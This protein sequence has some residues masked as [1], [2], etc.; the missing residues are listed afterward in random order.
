MRLFQDSRPYL[1]VGDDESLSYE[2]RLRRYRA[3]AD[4]YFS[5]DEYREFGETVLPHLDEATVELVESPEFDDMLVDAVRT[6]F[7]QHE[8]ERF[9]AHYRGLLS[10]WAQ[11]QR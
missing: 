8:H 4:E 3:I 10:S 11:D 5:A 9:V 7:P 6:T 1:E 2:E